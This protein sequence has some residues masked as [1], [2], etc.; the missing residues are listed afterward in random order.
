MCGGKLTGTTQ[1][2]GKDYKT[3]YY[4]CSKYAAGYKDECQ[5]RYTVPANLVEDHIVSLIVKDLSKYRDDKLLQ[6]Q[7][8]DELSQILNGQ[9]SAKNRLTDQAEALDGKLVKLREHLISMAPATAKAVGLY[10]EAR[11]LSEERS[12]IDTEIEKTQTGDT[13]VP[14]IE[15]VGAQIEREFGRLQE[16]FDA[17]TVEEKRELIG[18]YVNR[19]EAFPERQTVSISLYPGVL[20]QMVAGVEFE[21]TTLYVH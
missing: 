1:T 12:R 18:S 11:E 6:Q 7:V 16:V 21:P 17:G 8:E 5:K 9:M 15:D 19:V 14:S 3:R 10:D 2:S 20:S 13:V 4:T